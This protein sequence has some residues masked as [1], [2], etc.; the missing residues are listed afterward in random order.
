MRS[1]PLRGRRA[2]AEQAV[3]DQAR[4]DFHGHGRGG[5]APGNRIHVGATEAH[6]A[7]A[8]QSAVI[9]GGQFERRQHC[10]LTDLL[11]RDL[12]D[13]DAGVNIRPVRTL[14]V[15]AVQEHG[16][17]A[18]VV[19]AIIAGSGRPGHLVGQVADHHHLILE[20]LQRGE[21]AGKLER[22]FLGGRPVGHHAAVRDEA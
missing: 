6:V 17:R 13:G 11:R 19:A 22:A 2:V 7:G 16:R 9:L 4:I 15:D 18:S 10:F 12:V 20:G 21:R 5:C 3:E 8:D 14:G 1:Q